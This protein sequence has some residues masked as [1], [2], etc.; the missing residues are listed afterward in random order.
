MSAASASAA[1]A[2]RIEGR[3]AVRVQIDRGRSRR[4]GLRSMSDDESTKG[5]E[6]WEGW[7]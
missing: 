3:A 7:G 4:L 5:V 6:K 2:N 1:V